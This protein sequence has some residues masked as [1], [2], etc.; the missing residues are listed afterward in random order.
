MKANM[1]HLELNQKSVIECR[2]LATQIVA[3]VRPIID[4]HS[5][6]SIERTALRLIGVEGAV[7]SEGASHPLVNVLVDQLREDRVLNKGAL[8]WFANAL[9]QS[10][11]GQSEFSIEDVQALARKAATGGTRL[12]QVP[13]LPVGEVKKLAV[14]LCRRSLREADR[15]ARAAL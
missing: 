7:S 2:R 1:A 13:K 11:P 6:V 12:S 15:K 10:Q 5:T 4:N 14:E 8:Y 3:K 9:M